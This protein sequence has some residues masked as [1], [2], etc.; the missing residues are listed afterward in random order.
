MKIACLGWGS[1]VWNPRG[2]PVCKPWFMDGPLLP[3]EFA[4]Q[5]KGDRITL[6]IVNHA[7]HI[8]SLWALMSVTDFEAAKKELADR[9]GIIEKNISKYIGFWSSSEYS[10]LDFTREIGD[11]AARMDLDAVVW[12][13]LPP[14]FVGQN[15]RMPSAEEVVTFLQKARRRVHS[16]S[17]P[18]D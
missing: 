11:W 18:T 5:S 7:V 6:V 10:N 12:T 16:K 17:T 4:R 9:E 13:A 15:E 2:L 14:K 1:L 3:I 8:R